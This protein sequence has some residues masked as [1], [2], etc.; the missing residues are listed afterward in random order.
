MQVSKNVAVPSTLFLDDA[1]ISLSA[2]RG[3]RRLEGKGVQMFVISGD[4]DILIENLELQGGSAD[5]GGALSIHGGARVEFVRCTIR[6]CTAQLGGAVFVSLSILRAVETSFF[7]NSA[8]V[9]GGAVYATDAVVTMSDCLFTKNSASNNGGA[10]VAT[11]R[12]HADLQ[13]SEFH[14][15]SAATHG[16]A[17]AVSEESVFTAVYSTFSRN[18]ANAPNGTQ[19]SGGAIALDSDATC[20]LTLSR[21]D[22]QVADQGGA[23][24]VRTSS[25]RTF[26]CNFTNNSAHLGAA[27][28]AFQNADWIDSVVLNVRNSSSTFLLNRAEL[29]CGYFY[30]APDSSFRHFT[31]PNDLA[32]AL[33][34][35]DD[36]TDDHHSSSDIL[37]SS[38]PP[39]TSVS[40]S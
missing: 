8:A 24:A 21:F 36:T 3:T 9:S 26:A 28:A 33:T 15:N 18:S 37:S 7:A 1:N 12:S 38:P 5:S 34:H 23:I 39:M 19:S 4:S 13:Y 10:F 6:S 32:K 35:D 30:L 29:C 31:N 20:G 2:I 22:S 11:R 14:N 25:L 17:I 40:S 27:V 16:G